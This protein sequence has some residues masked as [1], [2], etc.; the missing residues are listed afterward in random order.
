MDIL[1]ALDQLERSLDGLDAR[2][3]ALDE[4][5]DQR[6]TRMRNAGFGN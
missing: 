5:L 3:A 1:A 6:N 2:L 4:E